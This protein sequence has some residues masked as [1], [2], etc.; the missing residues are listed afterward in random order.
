MVD[1]NPGSV[2]NEE[3]CSIKGQRVNGPNSWTDDSGLDDKDIHE[4]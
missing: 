1:G 3:Y 2:T 4:G